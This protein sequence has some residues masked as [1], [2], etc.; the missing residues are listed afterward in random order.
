MRAATTPLETSPPGNPQPPLQFAKT[1][2]EMG[3]LGSILVKILEFQS[4]V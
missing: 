3:D 1:G 2:M 4:T